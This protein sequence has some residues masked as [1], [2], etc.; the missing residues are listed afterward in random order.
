M[1]KDLTRRDFK[2]VG[3]HHMLCVHA[4]HGNG[5][6]SCHCMLPLE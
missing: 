5:E 2:F 6:R 1:S 4:S 3:Q